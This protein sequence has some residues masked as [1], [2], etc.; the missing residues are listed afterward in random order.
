[1]SAIFVIAQNTY[2]EIF[3]DRIL[4]GILVFAF[5][6]IL[7]SLALGELSF[8]EQSRITIDFG[9]T[10]IHLSSMVLSIFVGSTLVGREIEKKTIL[11]LL[12]RPITRTQFVV[13]KSFGLMAVIAMSIVILAIVLAGLLLKIDQSMNWMFIVGL[14]GVLLEAMLLLSLTL[15]FGS[16]ASPMLSVSFSVGLFLIGHWLDSLKFFTE[17]SNSPAFKVF[18]QFISQVVPNLE[19]FNWRSLLVYNET[20]AGSK[21]LLASAYSL[22]WS[23]LLIALAATILRKRDLG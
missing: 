18:G 4:Y 11:T 17:K 3:R 10:A 22:G 7:L 20:L 23:S 16:F 9:F 5:L 15:F 8:A 21:I 14:Y 19:Y 2:R 12:V 6:L 1:M 13:G